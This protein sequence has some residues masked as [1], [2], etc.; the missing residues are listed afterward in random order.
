MGTLA[1]ERHLLQSSSNA[2]YFL[3][4]DDGPDVMEG[5]KLPWKERESVT[6]EESD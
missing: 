2:G 6:F 1:L 5:W 3:K 4:R